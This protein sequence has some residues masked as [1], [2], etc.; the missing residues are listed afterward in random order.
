MPEAVQGGFYLER[1]RPRDD[2]RLIGAT[3]RWS[4]LERLMLVGP[5][6]GE[7][8]MEE[9]R[10]VAHGKDL[11]LLNDYRA[12]FSPIYDRIWRSIND[13]AGVGPGGAAIPADQRAYFERRSV[14]IAAK[15]WAQRL[16][17]DGDAHDLPPHQPGYLIQQNLPALTAIHNLLLQGWRD[18][19][20]QQCLYRNLR[21]LECRKPD[22]YLPLRAQLV[23][24]NT[25]DGVWSQLTTAFPQLTVVALRTKKVRDARTVQV[26]LCY[27]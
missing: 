13:L 14:Q 21:D 7:L 8:T 12:R 18:S 2:H 3:F 25:N 16:I 11:H 15:T 24:C 19:L 22:E 9:V 17:R 4:E 6:L 5:V 26:C 10:Q 20:G 27:L 23:R 1:L